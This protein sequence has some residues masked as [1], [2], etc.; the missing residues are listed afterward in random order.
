[1]LILSGTVN[2]RTPNTCGWT[3]TIQSD[4]TSNQPHSSQAMRAAMIGRA[5]IGY[6]M[7]AHPIMAVRDS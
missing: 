3:A 2:N 1:V 6:P 4:I 5:L 7:S